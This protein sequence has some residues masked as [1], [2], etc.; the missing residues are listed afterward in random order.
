MW[1]SKNAEDYPKSLKM[2]NS[3]QCVKNILVKRRTTRKSIECWRITVAR[4]L[5]TIGG[6]SKIENWPNLKWRTDSRNAEKP[7]A[8]FCSRGLKECFYCTN[9][10]LAMRTDILWKLQAKISNL[11]PDQGQ[12]YNKAKFLQ[13]EGDALCFSR[14]AWC[15]HVFPSNTRKT[16]YWP[17]VQTVIGWDKLCWVSRTARV[18]TL[19]ARAEFFWWECT[20]PSKEGNTWNGCFL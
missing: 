13:K 5:N 16:Y 7:H 10:L 15:H 14:S 9:S 1:G 8:K 11:D 12:I 18:S 4:R 17:M 6:T 19:P 3:K 20:S 2:A